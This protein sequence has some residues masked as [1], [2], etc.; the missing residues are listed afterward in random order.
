MRRF[1]MADGRIRDGIGGVQIK[2]D[3]RCASMPDLYTLSVSRISYRRI[4][5]IGPRCCP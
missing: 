2:P 1:G 5:R 4:G 3:L